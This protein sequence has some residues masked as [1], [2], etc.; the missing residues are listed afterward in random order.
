MSLEIFYSRTD[1][2]TVKYEIDVFTTLKRFL[3][4]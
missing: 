2:K 4:K 3:K 1:S